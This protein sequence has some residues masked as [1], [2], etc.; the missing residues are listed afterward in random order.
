MHKSI[1]YVLFLLHPQ[2]RLAAPASYV[3]LCVVASLTYNYCFCFT[4]T[5]ASLAPPAS[6]V[7]T[8]VVAVLTHNKIKQHICASLGHELNYFL[9]LIAGSKWNCKW[10]WKIIDALDCTTR[11]LGYLR[12]IWLSFDPYCATIMIYMNYK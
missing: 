5:I 9:F 6:S 11:T 4:H 8:C 2:Y 7:L 10:K 12:C 1:Q 3:S